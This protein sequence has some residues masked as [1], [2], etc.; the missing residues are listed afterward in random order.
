MKKIIVVYCLLLCVVALW[1][2]VDTQRFC[3][4]CDKKLNDG[5]WYTKAKIIKVNYEVTIGTNTGV[6]FFECEIC[7]ECFY[8]MQRNAGKR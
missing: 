5:N 3:D 2:W 7:K 6:R 4:I 8:K 1:A